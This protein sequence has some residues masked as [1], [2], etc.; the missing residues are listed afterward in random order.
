MVILGCVGG[1]PHAPPSSLAEKV[2]RCPALLQAH[3]LQ[4]QQQLWLH[5]QGCY[6]RHEELDQIDKPSNFCWNTVCRT[7]QQDL[8]DVEKQELESECRK[9]EYLYAL[10]SSA[11]KEAGLGA[12]G[13][14]R[15]E[16]GCIPLT[17][18]EAQTEIL[19]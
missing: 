7:G 15:R 11:E 8:I 3:G 1:D 19:S 2:R 12:A 5:T 14:A 4:R 16:R 10:A 13:A 9:A 17:V 6:A 18:S